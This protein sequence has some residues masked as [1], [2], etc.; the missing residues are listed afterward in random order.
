VAEIKIFLP[1]IA[2]VIV[3]LTIV[4]CVKVKV[5]G[6]EVTARKPGLAAF[7]TVT[8]HEVATEDLSKVPE[9]MQLFGLAFAVSDPVPDPPET[10]RVTSVF[11]KLFRTVLVMI[12]GAWE[13][14]VGVAEAVGVA[15]GVA[16][17][18]GV[19]EAVGEAEAVGVAETVGV[20]E[21]VGVWNPFNPLGAPSPVGPSQ[22]IP[23]VQRS[24][25]VQFP[26]LP[27]VT[28]KKDVG[29]DQSREAA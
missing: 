29:A 26:L 17:A 19:G 15:V 11:T 12:K 3:G 22:P 21:A 9:I 7:V 2:N 27:D 6:V 13:T 23:A 16:E 20:A 28:S 10:V 18:V 5:T 1:S 8:M 14:G 24:L 4:G 25:G